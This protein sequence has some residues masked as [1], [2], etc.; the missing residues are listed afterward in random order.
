[1]ADIDAACKSCSPP[2]PWPLKGIYTETLTRLSNNLI[3]IKV[4][5]HLKRKSNCAPN[6]KIS[7]KF[8]QNTDVKVTNMQEL[9]IK[10]GK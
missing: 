1:M 4:N 9:W 6:S 3:T 8:G 2:T 7:N 10:S 5:L